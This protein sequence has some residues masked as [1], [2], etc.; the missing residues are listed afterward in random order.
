[1][2]NLIKFKTRKRNNA[3][4]LIKVILLKI[5]YSNIVANHK[6][7]IAFYTKKRAFVVYFGNK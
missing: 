6:S 2:K 7:M 3:T 4:A 1:M 5:R